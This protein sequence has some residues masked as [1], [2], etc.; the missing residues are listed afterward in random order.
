[1]KST[2]DS[3]PVLLYLPIR[4]QLRFRPPDQISASLL[5]FRS[6]LSFV[7][8]LPIRSHLR[9]RPLDQISASLQTSRS[10]LSLRF[11]PPDQISSYASDLPIRLPAILLPA[12]P[13]FK[14]I[15]RKLTY[16]ALLKG[17]AS[18]L[19]LDCEPKE[20]KRPLLSKVNASR[21]Y[22]RHRRATQS[23]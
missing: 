5:T 16:K 23:L 20:I 14:A 2:G 3:V 21:C 1:M 7:S 15:L 8:D 13:Q 12:P 6:D 10:D 17:G 18:V 22:N 9:F 4:S 19:L 11:R